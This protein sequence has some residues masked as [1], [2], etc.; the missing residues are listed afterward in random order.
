[1]ARNDIRIV[2]PGGY[3]GEG[4]SRGLARGLLVFSGE[5]NL[6]GEGMG[7]GTVA[8]RS[9]NDTFFSRSWTDITGDNVFRRIFSL[10]TRMS[11][12]FR[13]RPSILLAR[14]IGIGIGLYM[15]VP[16]LQD[17]IIAPAIRLR[18]LIGIE[19]CFEHVPPRGSVEFTYQV[20]GRHVDIHVASPMEAGPHETLCLLNELSAAWLTNGWD[21]TRQVPPPPGWKEVRLAQLP[22]SLV[23]PV[24]G[25]LFCIGKLTVDPPVPYRVYQGRE[26]KG[27]LCW[28][29]FCIELCPECGSQRFP[30]VRYTVGLEP[31]ACS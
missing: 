3:T 13:G 7:I 28:A 10:D 14:L 29:G 20:S 17:I 25:I 8:L 24:H 26:H 9:D 12:R 6:A 23:D 31:G 11:W 5:L 2:P 30:E 16:W 1:M 22:V 21:G 19:P 15:K 4:R 27:D 18:I